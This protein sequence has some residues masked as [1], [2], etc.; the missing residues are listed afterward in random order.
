[1]ILPRDLP[2][3]IE[4]ILRSRP[5][6]IIPDKDPPFRQAAVL[7][8]LFFGRN[9]Y[10]VLLTKR[11]D[12]VEE[13]KGQISFPGGHVDDGDASLQDTALREAFEEVGLKREDVQVLGRTDDAR[14]VSSNFV[15]HPFVGFIPYPYPFRVDEREVRDL[16]EV[17]LRVFMAGD[18]EDHIGDVEYGGRTY[19]GV[20][21]P[22]G[23]EVIWGATARIMVNFMEIIGDKLHLPV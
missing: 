9:A 2:E 5:P 18:P 23:G 22:Y 21:Y 17:P 15:I 1:M 14:T 3:R 4:D 19:R 10:H 8:P 13:H 6:R 16:F 20:V 12:R 7:I 11:T